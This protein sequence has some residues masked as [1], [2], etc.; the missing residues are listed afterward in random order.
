MVS[1]AGIFILVSWLGYWKWR[2]LQIPACTWQLPIHAFLLLAKLSSR[3]Q[4]LL[5]PRLKGQLGPG[6]QA[7]R[8]CHPHGCSFRTPL[9]LLQDLKRLLQ[10]QWLMQVRTSLCRD[11]QLIWEVVHLLDF[12][13][14]T[15]VVTRCFLFV[16]F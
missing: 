13:F 7:L 9:Q 15:I 4:H 6:S 2:Q 16:R 3:A 14:V 12:L 1:F 11:C 10:R 5:W 8:T